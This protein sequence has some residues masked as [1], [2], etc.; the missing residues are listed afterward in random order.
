MDS[1]GRL[2]M[3]GLHLAGFAWCGFLYWLAADWSWLGGWWLLGPWIVLGVISLV[4]YIGTWTDAPAIWWW[5][6]LIACWPIMWT[7]GIVHPLN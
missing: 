3:F 7:G 5:P 2:V 6:Y 1:R 4:I